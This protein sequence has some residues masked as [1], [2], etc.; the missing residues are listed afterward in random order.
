MG[1]STDLISQFAKITTETKN[2]SSESTVFGTVVKYNNSM[3]VRIDG[4]DLLTPVTTT[5]GIRAGERVTVMIKNHSATVT[6]NI[7]SPS[8]SDTDIG[9]ISASTAEMSSKISE[10]EIVIADK[11]ST[12][13]FDTQVG[14]IDTLYSDNATIKKTLTANEASI[15]ELK[16][17]NVTITDR[18]AANDADID[19]LKTSKLDASVAAI[20]YAT[21]D[22]LEATNANIYNFKATYGDFEVLTANKFEAVNAS[23]KNLDTV[24]AT[25]TDLNAE[26]AR[27]DSLE[28]NSL[29]ASS[30]VIKN[31][32]ADVADIDTLIFGSA[33]GNTIQTS[34]ANAVIAQL[35]NAQ[36]KS[37][38]IESITADKITA[39]DIITDNVRVMSEDGKLL[40]SDET[41]QISDDTRV[42]VQIGKDAVGDYSINIWDNSGNLMFSE[43]GIT[44]D[45]IKDAI[46]RD[47]M[48]SDSANISAHKLNI[49]SL[50]EVINGSSQ[51]IKSSQILFD[52]EGQ[53]LDVVFAN[54]NTDI[55]KMDETVNSQGTQ[56]SAVQGQISSKVWEQDINTAI[57]DIEVGGRNLLLNSD[58]EYSSSGYMVGS[59]SPSTP[60]VSGVVYTMTINVTPAEGVTHFYSFVSG[61]WCGICRSHV[62]G[63]ERQ[64]ISTTFTMPSYYT[65]KTPDDNIANA[66]I[67]IYRFPNDGSVTA[68]S[69]I[70]W[71]KIE[72]GNKATDWTPA[73]ED[74]EK[75]ITFL[76]T[77]YSSLK[78]TTDTISATLVSHATEISNKAEQSEVTNATNRVSSL[79]MNL[80]GFETTVSETYVT[81]TELNDTV[82]DIETEVDNLTTRMVKAESSITQ[83]S[84]SITAVVSRT[85][86]VESEVTT[87]QKTADAAKKQL[88]HNASGESGTAGY[89]AFACITIKGSYQN[90]PIRFSLRNRGA[91]ASDIDVQFKNVSGSDPGL[92]SIRENGD[93][94]TWIVKIDTSTWYVLAKKSEAW[95]TIYVTDY[96]NTNASTDVKWINV[97][98]S[99]LPTE[100]ITKS[101]KLIGSAVANTV[102]TK[103]EVTQ[104]SDKITATVTQVSNNKTAISELELTANSLTSRVSGV[105]ADTETALTNAANAQS[106]IDSLKIGGRNL[107]KDSRHIRLYSNNSSLYP[108][109]SEILTENGRE[110]RRYTRTEITLTTTTMSLYSSIP[111]TQITEYLY[112]VECTFSFLIR[113]SH[114]TTSTV[115]TAL[116]SGGSSYT[117]GSSSVKHSIGT[118]WQR[119][120]VTATITQKYDAENESTILRFNPCIIP[121]PEGE[122]TN[123][124][125]DVCEWKFEKGN[126][127]SDWTPAPEDVDSGIEAVNDTALNAKETATNNSDQLAQAQTIIQQLSNSISAL[128]V[129]ESGE[130]LMTQDGD[131]WL[132]S[133][134]SYN[135]TL[136]N[137]SNDLNALT[138]DVGDTKN[139]VDILNQAVDDLG[140]LTEYIAI[141]TYNNQPCIEL[142]EYDSDFKLRITNTEIQFIEGT[143]I[144]AYLSN[145]KLYIEKAQVKGELQQGEFV[146]KA[147]SNGNLG[148]IWKG[149]D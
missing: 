10:F 51:T 145:Q 30:A 46:I 80:E 54:L 116:Y 63:I 122:I 64:T 125:I 108:I 7:T 101:T 24:Y 43:G 97:L 13:D 25:I 50:F 149:G 72:K 20:T 79:E 147:R 83:N 136:N 62:K 1:L 16:A 91:V 56:L 129:D 34:F 131:R 87:A 81:K 31:L 133:M 106:D 15:K 42:R 32:Q 65:D 92:Y 61:G 140:T 14:R 35:G 2:T 141:S 73:P 95:D 5:A 58:H 130:S 135:E 94:G 4:S 36:I 76:T 6:G 49:T 45:A 71:V 8:I 26:R 124:Y 59:Y 105:E 57:D 28:A 11:V 52:S 126:R 112:G 123:F 27:I 33:S 82:E 90:C 143:A 134:G 139:T 29:T 85:E 44:D 117:W 37:A 40:I 84:E 22:D 70:H 93:I 88:W 118:D 19:N 21:I 96:E 115:M 114:N 128:V 53:T 9:G 110:F 38:M 121:I 3:Y 77:Q 127:V 146:W 119:V 69:I 138:E 137:V 107:L 74:T 120:S 104:L 55:V 100:N 132:F 60:L 68:K 86:V 103:S 17:E 66:D 18:L 144:P 39:G 75:D 113:C 102:A 89:V 148:L 23:I 111:V 41:I 99:E 48:V 142:G 109:T 98:Y 47:D 78:Q 67:G 12:T